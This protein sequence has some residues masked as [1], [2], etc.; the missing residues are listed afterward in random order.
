MY[1]IFVY[2]KAS[3]LVKIIIAFIFFIPSCILHII[4]TTENTLN[5]EHQSV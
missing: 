4:K 1:T 3:L 2:P 5:L